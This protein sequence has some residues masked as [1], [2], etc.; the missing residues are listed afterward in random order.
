MI[1]VL[2]CPGCELVNMLVLIR[3]AVELEMAWG[4]RCGTVSKSFTNL[5]H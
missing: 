3:V 2:L 5:L 1:A 4:F